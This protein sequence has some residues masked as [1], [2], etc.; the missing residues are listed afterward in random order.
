[1]M[2]GCSPWRIYRKIILPLSLPVLAT[3]AIFTFIFTWDDFFGPLVYLSDVRKYTVALGLRTFV[4]SQGISDWN[5]VFA[6]SCLV[7]VPVFDG[8]RKEWQEASSSLGASSLHYWRHV[9]FPIILP[10]VLGGMVLCLGGLVVLVV[11]SGIND[12]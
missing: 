5:P 3:A 1:M 9:G 7:I 6:M 12:R 10:G 2:D 11:C 4:D 8:L